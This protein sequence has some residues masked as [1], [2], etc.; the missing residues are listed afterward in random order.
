[1]LYTSYRTSTLPPRW[2]ATIWTKQRTSLPPGSHLSSPSSRALTGTFLPTGW[3]RDVRVLRC[4]EAI[5]AY[6]Q[7]SGRLPSAHVTNVCLSDDPHFQPKYSPGPAGPKSIVE[8]DL[9]RETSHALRREYFCLARCAEQEWRGLTVGMI[10][11]DLKGYERPEGPRPE[12]EVNRMRW[13][14]STKRRL[15]RSPTFSSVRV[16]VP[17]DNTLF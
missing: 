2:L 14:R 8:A 12:W 11:R 3:L 16:H 10:I 5:S 15:K 17:L 7:K 4:P 13:R 1:M 6:L 9:E